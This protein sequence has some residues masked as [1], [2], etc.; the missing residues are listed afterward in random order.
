[1]DIKTKF[2]IGDRAYFIHDARVESQLVLEIRI[3]VSADF[4]VSGYPKYVSVSYR[5]LSADNIPEDKCFA[6]KEELIKS[7]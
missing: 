7:L 2:N 5:F 4:N 3:N 6:S 1:M